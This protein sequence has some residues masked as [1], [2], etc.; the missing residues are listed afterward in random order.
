MGRPKSNNPKDVRLQIRADRETIKKLDYC[1]EKNH[2]SRSEVVRQGI[3]LVY[4]KIKK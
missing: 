4:A 1:A 2:S 3:D